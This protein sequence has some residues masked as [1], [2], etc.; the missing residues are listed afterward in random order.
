M[1]FRYPRPPVSVE[2]KEKK[3]SRKNTCGFPAAVLCSPPSPRNTPCNPPLHFPPS[4][5]T[6]PPLPPSIFPARPSSWRKKSP[7][8]AGNPAVSPWSISA[9]DTFR[10]GPPCAFNRPT[11]SPCDGMTA[12]PSMVKFSAPWRRRNPASLNTKQP[13]TIPR[14]ATHTIHPRLRPSLSPPPPQPSQ[15][16][17]P[18]PRSSRPGRRFP[19]LTQPRNT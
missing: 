7:W 9:P 18:P 15:G 5:N 16:R 10:R 14:H 13:R 3:I 1:F 2:L 8:F 11:D 12:A 6:G 4:Q 17:H 19:R